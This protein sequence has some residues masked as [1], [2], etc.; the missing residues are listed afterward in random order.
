MCVCVCI[1]AFLHVRECVSLVAGLCRGDSDV[2]LQQIRAIRSVPEG[3]HTD[4][5]ADLNGVEEGG[6]QKTEEG[7][8]VVC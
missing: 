3:S 1:H 7:M 2:P 8:G 4:R 5:G 6:R